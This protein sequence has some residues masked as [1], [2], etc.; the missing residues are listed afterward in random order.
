MSNHTNDGLSVNGARVY[1]NNLQMDGV[2]SNDLIAS[3]SNSG[4]T[5]IPN[6]DSIVEFKVLTGQYDASYGRNAGAAVNVVTKTGT[7]EFHGSLF[8][9]FR[10]EALNANSFFFNA[11]GVRRGL[12]RQNQFGGTLGGPVKK[13]RILFFTSYQGTHQLNGI[14]P[15]A[16]TSFIG[17]PLTNDRS[18]AALG[19]LYGGQTGALGGVAVA[20]DGSNINPIALKLLNLKLPDGS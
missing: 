8:E 9:F 10:N 18:A 2:S 7:N 11:V 13:D 14:A 5:A 3:G 17:A 16:S 12:L 6:P 20:P 19:A 1:D 4:G 15:G